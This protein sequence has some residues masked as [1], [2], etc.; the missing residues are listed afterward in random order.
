MIGVRLQHWIVFLS[1]MHFLRHGPKSTAP[2]CGRQLANTCTYL[3]L[4][5]SNCNSYLQTATA[6]LPAERGHRVPEDVA[7]LYFRDMC[8]AS[9]TLCSGCGGLQWQWHTVCVCAGCDALQSLGY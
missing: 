4:Y 7:R 8:R 5:S 9:G 2:V 1:S 3:P 6:A